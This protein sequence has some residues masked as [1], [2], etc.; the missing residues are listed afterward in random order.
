MVHIWL[1]TTDETFYWFFCWWPRPGIRSL[2]LMTTNESSLL[3]V[4]WWPSALDIWL[5]ITDV[6]FYWFIRWWPSA[7]PMADQH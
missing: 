7:F 1:I 5:V 6:A 3:F 4:S 2:W